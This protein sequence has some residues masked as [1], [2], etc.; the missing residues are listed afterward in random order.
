MSP[1]PYAYRATGDCRTAISQLT[2][3]LDIFDELKLDHEAQRASEALNS[4]A[5]CIY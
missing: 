5:T 4:A 2:E 3:C 1:R